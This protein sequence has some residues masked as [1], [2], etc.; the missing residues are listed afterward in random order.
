[1]TDGRYRAT[2]H[3]GKKDGSGVELYDMDADP[4]CYSNL[5]NNPEN[6]PILARL[7]KWI[8]TH[9]EPDAPKSKLDKDAKK[10]QARGAK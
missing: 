7:K 10:R 3:L 2:W 9:D 5:A 6:A 8:P 1:M 4:L